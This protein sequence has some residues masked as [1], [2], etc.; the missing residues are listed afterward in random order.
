MSDPE[1]LHDERFLALWRQQKGI[2]NRVARR[3]SDEALPTRN[4]EDMLAVGRR[5][6][7]QS[8]R[9]YNPTRGSFINFLSGNLTRTYARMAHDAPVR[10]VEYI[11]C[12]RNKETGEQSHLPTAYAT[13]HEAQTACRLITIAGVGTEV[14]KRRRRHSTIPLVMLV[15]LDAERQPGDGTDG[16]TGYV[17]TLHDKLAGVPDKRDRA[18]IIR[19]IGKM[20][21]NRL[22][23]KLLLLIYKGVPL[24]QWN[25]T[26]ERRSHPRWWARDH[27]EDLSLVE[28]VGH[29]HPWV[30]RRVRRLRPI[31]DKIYQSV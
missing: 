11:V 18:S 13:E 12:L 31:V 4:L 19:M 15:S 30:S 3:W 14:V 2:V 24:E 25:H 20:V 8:S 26:K 7:W 22:D 6:L 28:A 27:R 5:V 17:T 1:Y 21:P 10:S 29:S 16:E 9:A 23:R